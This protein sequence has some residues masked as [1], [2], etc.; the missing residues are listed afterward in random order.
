MKCNVVCGAGLRILRIFPI[1]A[2]F[3]R[4]GV[5]LLYM[6][7]RSV[8]FLL[9]LSVLVSGC[10]TARDYTNPQLVTTTTT[11]L[12][13]ATVLAGH[14]ENVATGQTV[15]F[16]YNQQTGMWLDKEDLSKLTFSDGDIFRAT[17]KG[18]I[19]WYY[20]YRN[21]S[22]VVL[23]DGLPTTTTTTLP[24][25]STFKIGETASDGRIS[26]SLNGVRY[27]KVISDQGN[28]YSSATAAPGKRFAIVD[29]TVNN[30]ASDNTQYLLTTYNSR[31]T[32]PD[33]YAYDSASAT[34][35]LD[36]EFKNGDLLPLQKRRGE[37]A[38]EVPNNVTGFKFLYKF[39]VVGTTAIFDL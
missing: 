32:D 24:V 26:V 39:D 10:T 6:E 20:V 7:S 37:I 17:V 18:I 13:T 9:V 31:I 29:V 22:F 30:L 2:R 25:V 21:H 38:F 15:E 28:Y 34:Y 16:N 14:L 4:L 5:Q 11:T 36:K 33:G 12:N 27:A 19:P 23:P 3:I 35:Y 8:F 1:A